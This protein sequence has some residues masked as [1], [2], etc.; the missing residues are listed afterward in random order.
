MSPPALPKQ[1]IPGRVVIASLAA[2]PAPSGTVT[3]LLRVVQAERWEQFTIAG[4]E[5]TYGAKLAAAIN[6]VAFE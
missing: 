5:L 3:M 2:D 6:A 4:L 1:A